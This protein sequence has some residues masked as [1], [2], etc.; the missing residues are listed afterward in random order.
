MKDASYHLIFAD[1]GYIDTKMVYDLQQNNIH[2]VISLRNNHTYKLAGCRDTSEKE[3]KQA[4]HLATRCPNLILDIDVIVTERKNYPQFVLRVTLKM[5]SKTDEPDQHKQN[6]FRF[7][8][9]S[10]TDKVPVL[11]LNKLYCLF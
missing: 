2:Y 8:A 5:T 3:Y 11:F 7:L 6:Q 9:P 10:I 4:Q 1:R